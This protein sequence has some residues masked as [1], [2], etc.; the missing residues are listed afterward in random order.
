[1]EII[2]CFSSIDNTILFKDSKRTV[3][4]NVAYKEFKNGNVKNY[5][6]PSVFNIG[7]LGYGNYAPI[8]NKKVY[9]SWKSMLAR[10]CDIKSQMNPK[11]ISYIDCS[12]I[13]EWHNFQ[14][15]AKWYEEN[16]KP[17][18]DNTWQ[19]DKDIL[20]KGNKVYS[21]ETCC[22]VPKE[23][24]AIFS[25]LLKNR[26]CVVGVVREGKKF[27]S[28]IRCNNIRK[29]LGTFNTPEE[30]FQVYKTAKEKYIKEVADKWK[31]QITDKVYQAM[32]NYKIEITD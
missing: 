29:Y 24:N 30:A 3:V 25:S 20:V 12:I 13:E 15:F 1:M 31:D 17:W 8:N 14:N 9:S 16:W 22:F 18:M 27:K 21:P 5:N 10:C 26:S 11:N 6:L 32:Y 2:E 7:Y 4:Y 28:E 23:I 19:L